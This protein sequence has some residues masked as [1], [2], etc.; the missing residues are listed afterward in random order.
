MHGWEAEPNK[1]QSRWVH[2][3]RKYYSNAISGANSPMQFAPMIMI[4]I[5]G[6]VFANCEMDVTEL[7]GIL[8]IIWER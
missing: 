5:P 4:G 7:Y 2:L 1:E 6:E 8:K 3:L